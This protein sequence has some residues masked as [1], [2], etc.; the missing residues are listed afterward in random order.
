MVRDAGVMR[1][2]WIVEE[3]RPAGALLREPETVACTKCGIHALRWVGQLYI[4]IYNV[5]LGLAGYWGRPP[6]ADKI[7]KVDPECTG[8]FIE[9]TP[10]DKR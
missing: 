7:P 6:V 2:E 8:V 10:Q 5:V 3:A 4:T 1:H 9:W